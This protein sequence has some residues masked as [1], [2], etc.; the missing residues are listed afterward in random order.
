VWLK[1][2]DLPFKCQNHVKNQQIMLSNVLMIPHH[3]AIQIRVYTAQ[4]C[5]LSQNF[6]AGGDG[7]PQSAEKGGNKI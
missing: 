1:F 3:V 2:S 4:R 5:K 7:F 6:G